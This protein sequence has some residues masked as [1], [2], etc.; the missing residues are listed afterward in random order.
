MDTRKT[1]RQKPFDYE[2]FKEFW[3]GN[4]KFEVAQGLLFTLKESKH[5]GIISKL[6]FLNTIARDRAH[7]YGASDIALFRQALDHILK[8]TPVWYSEAPASSKD[9][10]VI[11]ASNIHVQMYSGFEPSLKKFMQSLLNGTPKQEDDNFWGQFWR[12]DVPAV[13]LKLRMFEELVNYNFTG[14]DVIKKLLG[15]CNVASRYDSGKLHIHTPELL[16]ALAQ[17]RDPHAMSTLLRLL[18]KREPNS[19]FP[20]PLAFQ[21]T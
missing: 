8:L 20:Y 11:I 18:A 19:L 12:Y 6:L 15:M 17:N 2:E 5:I 4:Q 14:I 13:L 10:V 9:I 1:W 16:D 3:N 21:L 7:L